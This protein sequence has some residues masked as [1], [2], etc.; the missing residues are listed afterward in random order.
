MIA[1]KANKIDEQ[2]PASGFKNSGQTIQKAHLR[3]AL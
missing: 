2:L 3:L 1:T